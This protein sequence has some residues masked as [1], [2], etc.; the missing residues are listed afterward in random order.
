[1]RSF[2]LSYYHVPLQ[3][4]ASKKQAQLEFYEQKVRFH[5]EAYF[6]ARYARRSW[7]CNCKSQRSGAVLGAPDKDARA[8]TDP[9]HRHHLVPHH[10]LTSKHIT[11]PHVPVPPLRGPG[12]RTLLCSEAA[13]GLTHCALE[14][15][16][17]PAT[18]PIGFG[19]WCHGLK[20]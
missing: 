11:Q 6:S 17:K 15:G 10:S 14:P 5:H 1:M 13:G 12:S 20:L 18:S 16:Q 19:Y 3:R 9:R 4:V 2:P 8:A 7:R